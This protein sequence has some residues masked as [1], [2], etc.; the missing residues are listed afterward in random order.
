D[1]GKLG[2]SYAVFCLKKKN[3]ETTINDLMTGQHNNPVRVVAFN[4]A[5]HWSKDAS[6]NIAREIKLRLYIAGQEMPSSI[7]AFVER[8]LGSDRHVLATPGPNLQPDIAD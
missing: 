5:E 2:I 1:Y 7:E 3:F 4:H 6:E 8:H